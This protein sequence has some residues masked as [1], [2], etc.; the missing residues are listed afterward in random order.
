MRL[1]KI[2]EQHIEECVRVKLTTAGYSDNLDCVQE[3]ENPIC[4]DTKRYN[5]Q[6]YGRNDCLKEVKM[7]TELGEGDCNKMLM[8]AM[9]P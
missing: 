9:I 5:A 4:K 7:E 2:D 6:I 8:D 1:V 3:Y